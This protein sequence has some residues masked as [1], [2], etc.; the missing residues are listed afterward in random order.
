MTVYCFRKAMNVVPEY[1]C[2]RCMVRRKCRSY[3][4]WLEPELPFVFKP[5]NSRNCVF[6]L[7]NNISDALDALFA[8]EY[9][10]LKKRALKA[11]PG[12]TDTKSALVRLKMYE[13]LMGNGSANSGGR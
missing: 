10:L 13:L 5:G 11:L 7:Q 12:V 9:R 4:L 3:Q 6:D 1:R 2:R 8:V